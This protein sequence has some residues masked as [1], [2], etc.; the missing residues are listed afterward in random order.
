MDSTALVAPGLVALMTFAAVLLLV[1]G[2]WLLWRGWRGPAAL[3]LAGRLQ[4]LASRT[5]S[6]TG[7]SA[8]RP[9]RSCPWATPTACRGPHPGEG[10]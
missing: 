3:K 9:S 8:R 7:S 6:P 4:G 1:A 2:L 5:A 10:P